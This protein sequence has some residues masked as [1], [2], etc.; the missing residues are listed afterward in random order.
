MVKPL[1][2]QLVSRAATRAG[3][4]LTERFNEKMTKHW[5]GCRLAGLH[6]RA[7][8][9]LWG[10]EESVV[11]QLTKEMQLCSDSLTIQAQ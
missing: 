8:G 5:E 1:Q 10:W 11:V 7:D 6:P 4:A 2:T 3:H 9:D